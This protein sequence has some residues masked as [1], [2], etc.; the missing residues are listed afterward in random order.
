V[1]N[2]VVGIT[3]ASGVIYAQRLL[4]ILNEKDKDYVVHLIISDAS[5]LVIEHELGIHLD[6]NNP[7]IE[8][9]LGCATRNNILYYDNSDVGAMIASSQY[10]IKAMIIVP[11]SMNTLCSVACGIS[12]NLIQR[13]A[14][15]TL[16][17]QRRLITVPRETPLSS[18]HLEA[19]LKLSSIGSCVLPAMPGFYH[20]PKTIGDQVDFIVAKILDMLGIEHS[21]IPV[22]APGA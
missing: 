21:L 18:I 2:I 8:E 11:C 9:F 22:W 16:K 14:G 4:Q 19:M 6:N 17:E 13:V 7:N 12:Q 15:I 1:K 10:P 5:V 3:G 20:N